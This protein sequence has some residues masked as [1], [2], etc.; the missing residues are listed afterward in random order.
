MQ[1]PCQSSP[2]SFSRRLLV[3]KASLLWAMDVAPQIAK[4]MLTPPLSPSPQL[5]RNQ[6]FR[7]WERSRRPRNEVCHFRPAPIAS[8]NEWLLLD[9][10]E[11][12][13]LRNIHTELDKRTDSETAD[14]IRQSII[15]LF[16]VLLE[17]ELDRYTLDIG[18]MEM[19]LENP[20]QFRLGCLIEYFWEDELAI[21]G[22]ILPEDYASE[23]GLWTNNEFKGDLQIFHVYERGKSTSGA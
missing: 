8:P 18:R 23:Q 20:S 2:I 4:E 10:H 3:R 7:V 9:G 19:L 15:I 12:S 22:T 14:S 13:L 11:R 16:E 1:I 5:Q 21:N 17:Y 6:P